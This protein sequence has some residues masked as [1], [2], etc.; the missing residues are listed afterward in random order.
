MRFSYLITD[1]PPRDTSAIKAYNS[2]IQRSIRKNLSCD[3]DVLIWLVA[4]ILFSYMGIAQGHL[5]TALLHIRSG[6]Q[7]FKGHQ[8]KFQS[9]PVSSSAA[10]GNL[11]FSKPSSVRSRFEVQAGGFNPSP[12]MKCRMRQRICASGDFDDLETFL[13]RMCDLTYEGALSI[14]SPNRQSLSP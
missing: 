12:R 1:P 3:E 9:A 7:A 8:G 5:S 13:N 6:F 11:L 2:A 14:V 10:D 4:C